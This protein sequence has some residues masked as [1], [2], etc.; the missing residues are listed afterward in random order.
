MSNKYSIAIIGNKDTI[1]GFKALGLDTF[2][3][4]DTETALKLLFTLTGESVEVDS[5]SSETKAKYAIIF[6]TENL[7]KD[8]SKEDYKKLGKKALPAI[9]PL[10]GSSGATGFGLNKL[11]RIVEQAVGS[12]ILK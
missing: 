3:A 1:L 9:I 6:I 11:K 7:A 12:D 8:I 5:K 4:N 10:P 2:D